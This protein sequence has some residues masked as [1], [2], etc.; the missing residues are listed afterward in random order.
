MLLNNY[1]T[2][3]RYMFEFNKLYEYWG[4]RDKDILN[5]TFLTEYDKIVIKK[6]RENIIMNE[7]SSIVQDY[8]LADLENQL[9]NF[10][11]SIVKSKSNIKDLNFAK[12][13]I[14]NNKS[15]KS[16]IKKK[17]NQK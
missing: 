4:P 15:K 7:A 16:I 10:N 3:E 9:E 1:L 11:L 5:Y 13:K 2:P 12:L 17:I 14:S 6:E 8:R